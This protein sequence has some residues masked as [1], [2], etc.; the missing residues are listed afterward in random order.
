MSPT[1]KAWLIAA[2][3]VVLSGAATAAGSFVAG[4]TFKQGLVIVSAAVV[5]SFGKWLLQHPIPGGAQ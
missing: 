2:A 3:N 1:F 4:T 5:M